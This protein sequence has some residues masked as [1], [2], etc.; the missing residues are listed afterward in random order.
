MYAYS[1]LEYEAQLMSEW[2]EK[3]MQRIKKQT[4]KTISSSAHF[5]LKISS[6]Q[7]TQLFIY[8]W[9]ESLPVAEKLAD[10][11]NLCKLDFFAL[12]DDVD[13]FKE[14]YMEN[15]NGPQHYFGEK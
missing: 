13:A 4:L 15:Y 14:E 3:E 6:D 8:C 10:D 7:F 2:I 9:Q 1:R 12:M 5:N 11:L